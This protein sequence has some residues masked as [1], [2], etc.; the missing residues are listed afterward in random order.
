MNVKYQ[1]AISR[2]R[3]SSHQLSIETGRHTIPITPLKDRTCKHCNSPEID[4]EMHMFL[5]CEFHNSERLVLFSELPYSFAPLRP[6]YL[7]IKL[8]SNC[9]KNVIRSVG[10]YIYTCFDR[11]KTATE[12]LA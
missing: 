12:Q 8:L 5:S 1:K 6:E 3:S 7:F 11:R 2:F 4:D 10:K 9:H